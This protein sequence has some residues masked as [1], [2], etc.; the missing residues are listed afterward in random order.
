MLP[1]ITS[2]SKRRSL[3]HRSSH[4]ILEQAIE[5]LYSGNLELMEPPKIQALISQWMDLSWR[6]EEWSDNLTSVGGLVTGSE[7]PACPGTTD[8]RMAA[9][10]LLTIQYYRM[11][12]LANFPPI[13]QFLLSAR[14]AI[15]E[16]QALDRLR[17]RLPFIV[18]D[19]WHAVRELR[20]VISVL[21]NTRATFTSTFAAWY[22]CNYTSMIDPA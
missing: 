2:S 16:P 19:D 17:Q 13:S 4:S 20:R 7:L 3:Y 18:Q 15:H 14:E 10:V 9:R 21:S 22:T 8:G 6:I 1:L 5:S 12:M 11:R